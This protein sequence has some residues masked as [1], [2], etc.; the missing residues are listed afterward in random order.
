MILFHPKFEGQSK[1]LSVFT[2]KCRHNKECIK[3]AI[4]NVHYSKFTSLIQSLKLTAPPYNKKKFNSYTN[5][6][7]NDPLIH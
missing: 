5:P 7:N 2:D 3:S 1:H 4:I 6:A